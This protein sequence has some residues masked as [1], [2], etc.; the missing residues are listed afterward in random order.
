MHL[1]LHAGAH[2]HGQVHPEWDEVQFSIFAAFIQ[3]LTKVTDGN[4]AA[5]VA[6]SMAQLEAKMKTLE[7]MLKEIKKESGGACLHAIAACNTVEDSK[8]ALNKLY[9]A[10]MSLKR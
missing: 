10:N 7:A 2:D 6:G 9:Q 1:D 4:A 3:F 5:G 8:K